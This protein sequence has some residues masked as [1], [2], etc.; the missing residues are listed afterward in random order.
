MKNDN[1]VTISPSDIWGY[2]VDHA[3]QL[4][5]MHHK[6]AEAGEWSVWITN[7]EGFPTFTVFYNEEA[8][9][10]YSA[11]SKT[12]SYDQYMLA[13]E[14][15]GISYG[16]LT[17]S[18][19]D[20]ERI[21]E[22]EQELDDIISGAISDILGSYDEVLED[23]DMIKTVKEV[24]LD[25]LGLQFRLPVYRPMRLKSIDGE[26]FFTSDYPYENLR[27]GDTPLMGD[28]KTT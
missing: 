18:D 10:E 13:L 19:D 17:A 2:F 20:D 6:C 11:V 9:Q 26:E 22:R 28:E 27:A 5:K 4:E 16:D 14:D 23:T 25:I 7:D 3:L 21:M 24:T 15:I 12:D 1:G 8:M